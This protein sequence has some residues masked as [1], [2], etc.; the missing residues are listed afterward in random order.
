MNSKSISHTNK[1][2]QCGN[3]FLQ[4]CF[5]LFSVGLRT[6]KQ[7]LSQWRKPLLSLILSQRLSLQKRLFPACQNVRATLLVW[8]TEKQIAFIEFVTNPRHLIGFGYGIVSITGVFAH[9][10]FDESVRDATW[11]YNW[12]YFFYDLRLPLFI[13][14]VPAALMMF[15]PESKAD[16]ILFGLLS[17]VGVL[18]LAH[19]INLAI[20]L[21]N[22][23]FTSYKQWDT[24]ET[25]A[26]Y[27]SW[28]AWYVWIICASVGM[29]FLK[30]AKQLVYIACHAKTRPVCSLIGVLDLPN[31][32]DATKVRHARTAATEIKN[33]L[34]KF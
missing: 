31:V 12:F 27:E 10:L 17:A 3:Y 8:I 16:W 7:R 4:R 29:G 14:F 34:I 6:M 33:L 23:A 11:F 5:F 25:R 24:K 19:Y 30:A 28:P 13:I 2:L 32:D 21:Q 22:P 18:L 15:S 9:T 1:P 26:L 20:T